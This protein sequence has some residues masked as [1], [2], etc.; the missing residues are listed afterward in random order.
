MRRV[1]VIGIICCS[2]ARLAGAKVEPKGFTTELTLT[3]EFSKKFE[4]ALD[5]VELEKLGCHSGR[6]LPSICD[7]EEGLAGQAPMEEVRLSAILGGGKQFEVEYVRAVY[8][9]EYAHT[10]TLGHGHNA[11]FC[12]VALTLYRRANITKWKVNRLYDFSDDLDKPDF[13]SRL[14]FAVQFSKRYANSSLDGPALAKLAMEE[15]PKAMAV[16]PATCY[17][18]TEI[19]KQKMLSDIA[20][21][22]TKQFDKQH[23]TEA[24]ANHWYRTQVET[25]K[26]L[27]RWQFSTYVFVVVAVVG[28]ALTAL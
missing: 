27:K 10:L 4:L 26:S 14:A 2:F 20:E 6:H 16:D 28:L 19:A 25:A 11:I 22:V 23:A 1:V 12:A 21:Y 15:F 8:L 5:P 9:H 7:L 3:P 13:S 24:R 17:Y 18:E